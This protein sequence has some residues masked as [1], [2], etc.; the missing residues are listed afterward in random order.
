MFL[1][2]ESRITLIERQLR[3]NRTR[4]VNAIFKSIVNLAYLPVIADKYRLNLVV[5]VF[6]FIIGF[7][8]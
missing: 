2:V 5:K 3:L 8:K 6:Y 1:R 7:E 4:D